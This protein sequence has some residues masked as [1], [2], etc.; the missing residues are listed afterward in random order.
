MSKSKNKNKNQYVSKAKKKGFLTGISGDLPT[1]GNIKNTALETGKD[2]LVGVIGGGLIGA[3]IGKPSLIIGTIITGAGHYADNKLAT[4]F[5][6]GMMAS[7]GFQKGKAVSGLEG[8][9]GVKERMQAYKESFS[10][11]L[12]LDKIIKTKA[13][14]EGIGEVQYFT[15]PNAELQGSLAA[16]DEIENQIAESGMQFQGQLPQEQ[17][18][19]AGSDF[20]DRNF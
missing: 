8:I 3:A 12:Y 9:D 13:V 14:V 17:Y 2:L 5:G 10:E 19:I 6:I 7:N 1:K 4:I 11:K 18:E 16:L 15:Y 20:E